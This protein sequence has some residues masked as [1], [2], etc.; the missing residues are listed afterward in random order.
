MIPRSPSRFQGILIWSGNTKGVCHLGDLVISQKNKVAKRWKMMR[1]L[2]FLGILSGNDR[3]K[4][5]ESLPGQGQIDVHGE[6]QNR[7]RF[8]DFSRNRSRPWVFLKENAR[9]RRGGK[10]WNH[11]DDE[12]IWSRFLFW[13]L[14]RIGHVYSV[15]RVCRNPVRFPVTEWCPHP[16]CDGK[17]LYNSPNPWEFYDVKEFIGN[18]RNSHLV[19]EL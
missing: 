14:L 5:P 16:F 4:S 2:G 9:S 6:I 10:C 3:P 19:G 7:D 13:N 1:S 11:L 15:F 17:S 18:S 8:L 12:I